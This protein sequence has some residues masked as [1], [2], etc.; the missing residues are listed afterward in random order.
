MNNLAASCGVSELDD[1]ICLKG[2][3]PNVFI[4]VQFR[5]RLW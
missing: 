3:T 5:T 1:E 2:V 4:G